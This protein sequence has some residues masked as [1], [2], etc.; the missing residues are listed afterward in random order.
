M[1]RV[2]V[3]DDEPPDPAR[4][5]SPTSARAATTSTRPAPGEIALQLAARHRPDLVVLDLGLPGISGTR[6]DRG[7]ARLDRRADRDPVG[8]RQPSATRSP[9]ST[10]APTI[11]SPSRSAW[12]SSSRA[13]APR[14]AA[15]RPSAEE[16][17]VTTPDFTVDF[18]TKR[19]HRNGAEVKLTPTEWHMVEVLVRNAG[20]ARRAAAAAPGGVGP[21]VRHRDELPPRPHGPH[22]PE[23]RTRTRRPRYFLTEP[24]MGYRFETDCTRRLLSPAPPAT[25]RRHASAPFCHTEMCSVLS[26]VNG[27][28]DQALQRSR[29]V[30]PASRAIR[31]SSAG[32]T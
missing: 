18:V 8:T 22:P 12:A 26:L 29:N 13:C 20:Q 10:P 30:I 7:P 19:V 25:R 14:C 15:S 32:Q 2:L 3:V 11:T 4:R 6:R 24:G 28:R 9:P 21:G 16:P 17:V 5:W 31:S 23:A 27:A 1:T